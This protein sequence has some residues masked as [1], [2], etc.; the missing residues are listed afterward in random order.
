MRALTKGTR[1]KA[2]MALLMWPVIV[3]GLLATCYLE[4]ESRR[5]PIDS[6]HCVMCWIL[7]ML[8]ER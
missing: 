7:T 4:G 1:I 2:V 8:G 6:T 3:V 5:N